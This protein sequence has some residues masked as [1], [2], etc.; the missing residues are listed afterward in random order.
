VDNEWAIGKELVRGQQAGVGF[1]S[2]SLFF[3]F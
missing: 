2:N 1:N 3:A